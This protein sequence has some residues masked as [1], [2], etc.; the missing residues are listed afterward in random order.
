MKIMDVE[1]HFIERPKEVHS[2]VALKQAEPR[3]HLGLEA[4]FFELGMLSW[5][6][7]SD[8]EYSVINLLNSFTYTL[9]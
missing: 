3:S 8:F 5:L 1:A 6:Y 4:V 7:A 9:C 2:K